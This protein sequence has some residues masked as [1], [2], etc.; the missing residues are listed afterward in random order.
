LPEVAVQLLPE[1]VEAEVVLPLPEVVL[2]LP[3][4]A[5]RA[6]QPAAVQLLQE[7]Y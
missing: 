4:V 6:E 2:P 5:G 1:V 3:E 7:E